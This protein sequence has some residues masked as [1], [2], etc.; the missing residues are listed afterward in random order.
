[1]PVLTA[2]AAPL[3]WDCLGAKLLGASK[4]GLDLLEGM[5]CTFMLALGLL[6]CSCSNEALPGIAAPAEDPHMALTGSLDWVAPLVDLDVKENFLPPA[7]A[8]ALLTCF[9]V[10]SVL[11]NTFPVATDR[12][13]FVL[14]VG[15]AAADAGPCLVLAEVGAGCAPCLGKLGATELG[16]VVAL[17]IDKPL[18]WCILNNSTN[19]SMN[20]A[21]LYVC[22]Y[23]ALSNVLQ[24]FGPVV[25][26]KVC[27]HYLTCLQSAALLVTE[28]S[29][30]L[31]LLHMSCRLL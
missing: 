8:E 14:L 6:R 17:Q 20:A 2:T 10:G 26:E 22:M 21:S 29:Q 24:P 3:F 18:R 1:M 23:T 13:C 27:N 9:L 15:S 4:L 28:V 11:P 31:H 30:A 7:M 25:H 12:V 16:V 19:A 5:P